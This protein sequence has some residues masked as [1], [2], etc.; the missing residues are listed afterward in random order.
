[1]SG[2]VCKIILYNNKKPVS[3]TNQPATTYASGSGNLESG[4]VSLH[5]NTYIFQFRFSTRLSTRNACVWISVTLL[6]ALHIMLQLL[7]SIIN[8]LQ[9]AKY[10]YNILTLLYEAIARS[11]RT[12]KSAVSSHQKGSV[13][14]LV[15]FRA[16]A[17]VISRN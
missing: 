5:A 8:V 1:M 17:S 4:L 10:Y 14:S 15:N 9:Q 12:E 13:C 11:S 6:I 2:P 7:S 16:P 3:V